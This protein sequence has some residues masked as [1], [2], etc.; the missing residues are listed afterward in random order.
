MY[1]D[2]ETMSA[3]VC[4]TA[5]VLAGGTTKAVRVP[6][7]SYLAVGDKVAVY[8]GTAAPVAISSIDTKESDVYDTINLASAITGIKENDILIEAEAGEGDGAKV[9]PR[10]TPN[11]IV[12]EDK[13]FTGKGLPT[14]DAA[15]EAVVLIPSLN[16]PVLPEWKTGVALKDNPNI[17]FIYQ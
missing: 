8:G 3:N 14:L 7:G 13:E 10:F 15:F 6:K 2:F 9:T 4:K 12:G 17:I 11:M 16:F 1:V 5:Q